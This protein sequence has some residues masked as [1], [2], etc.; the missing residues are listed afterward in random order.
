MGDVLSPLVWDGST[1]TIPKASSTQNGYLSKEDFILFSGGVVVPVTSFN[2]RTGEVVLLEDDVLAALGYVPLDKA[3]DTMTGPL[4]LPSVDP[5]S[6]YAAAHK[7]YVDTHA[8]GAVSLPATWYTRDFNASGSKLT[9]T[10]TAPSGSSTL[11]LSAPSDFV[12]GQGILI[13]G[14]GSSSSGIPGALLT[15]VDAIAGNVITLHNPVTSAV[16]AVAANVMHDETVAINAALQ[17]L[18]DAKGGKLVFDPGTYNVNGP[19]LTSHNSI[20][21]LPY[22]GGGN[23]SIAITMIGQPNP[24]FSFSAPNPLSMPQ[25]GVI[26]QTQVH[27][28]AASILAATVYSPTISDLSW[29]SAICLSMDG[30]TFRT[31]ADPQ[32]SGLDLAAINCDLRNIQ[33]DTGTDFQAAPIATATVN[34]GLRTGAVSSGNARHYLENVVIYNY[35][36]GLKFSELVSASLVQVF[37]CRV[38]M[39]FMQSYYGAHF[40]SCLVWHC[41]TSIYVS[42]APPTCRAVLTM[43]LD[44]EY[45]WT[46]GDQPLAGR[47]LYDPTNIGCGVIR[48]LKITG[49]GQGTKASAS[50]TG[51]SK[52]DVF[53]LGSGRHLTPT[54]IEND[55]TV[56]GNA[57]LGALAG[58]VSIGGRTIT[59][60]A[61]NSATATGFSELQVPNASISLLTNL[62]SYWKLDEASGT[63]ADSRGSAPFAPVGTVATAT[64][65]YGTLGASFAGSTHLEASHVSLQTGNNSFTVAFW[66]KLDSKSTNQEFLMKGAGPNMNE[67]FIGYD[68]TD[69][70]FRYGMISSSNFYSQLLASS[71]GSP[72]VGTWYLIIVWFDYAN[73]EM[74]IQVNNGGVDTLTARLPQNLDTAPLNC[75]SY[76]QAYANPA[77]AT[78]D[79]IAF[80]KPRVLDPVTRTAIWN[81]G[82]GTPFSSWT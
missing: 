2:T 56:T 52:A 81:G 10:G 30:F 71:A 41:P 78:I 33:I 40:Y 15:K 34:Y 47:D 74:H 8:G 67:Y 31:Y 68:A 43:T 38:G 59:S 37:R 76:G 54:I 17:A 29:L 7:H 11:T 82:A 63:R 46:G 53:D 65:R 51:F 24:G 14:A 22:N 5:P 19:V 49:D 26:I 55:L 70:R 45:D 36:T 72:V 18:F 64:G 62:V 79:E 23:S 58:N 39:E 73:D 9:F 48:I 32:I 35:Y 50:V 20:L 12:V 61:T 42:P 57:S 28:T 6:A 69:D 25:Y 16:T 75:G 77:F 3:G 60:G 44:I 1:L 27:N 66:V 80:W 4:I 21:K 13:K